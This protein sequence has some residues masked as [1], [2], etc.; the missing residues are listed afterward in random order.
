MTDHVAILRSKIEKAESKV[1]RYRKSLESADSELSD[2]V[3]ALRVIEGIANDTD[4]NGAGTTTT[5]TR[6]LDIVRLLGVGRAKGQPPAD[7]YAS[8]CLIGSEDIKIDTFRTTIW[9]MKDQEFETEGGSYIVYGDSGNYWK[10]QVEEQIIPPPPAINPP[11]R[12]PPQTTQP[13]AWPVADENPPSPPQSGWPPP[14]KPTQWD[15]DPPF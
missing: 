13:H 15:E 14:P 5:M 11:A 10:E 3:T 1:Q 8:Y 12:V 6:Q 7:L 4:S 2:L 9:R